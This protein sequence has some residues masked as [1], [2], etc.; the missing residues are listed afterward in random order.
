MDMIKYHESL[1]RELQ[2]LK[3]RV[4]NLMDDPHWLTDGEWKETVLRSVLRKHLPQSVQVSRGFIFTPSRCSTQIDI[5]I[6]DSSAPLIFAEGDLVFVS[7]GAV[8]AIIEVKSKV[9]LSILS[10]AAD[11]LVYN[12]ELIYQASNNPASIV[13]GRKRFMAGL[14]SF[15]SEINDDNSVLSLLRDK[16]KSNPNK[17][18]DMLSIGQHQFFRYWEGLLTPP[19]QGWCSYNLRNLSPS[20]FVGN[21]VEHCTE[22]S[23]I[24]DYQTW[25]PFE[26]KETKRTGHIS[27]EWAQVP[28]GEHDINS[29][30]HAG[31]AKK[32]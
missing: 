18:I 17:A 1:N 22:S 4:R 8:R 29:A 2:A 32:G 6:H 7:P 24:F 9:T 19:Y 30:Q 25:F 5:L 21:M 3:D 14:F 11:K 15:D 16:A 31:K 23:D 26:T 27:L 20:Y 28:G 10:E 13:A 12:S